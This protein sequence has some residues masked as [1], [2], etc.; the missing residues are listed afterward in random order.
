M[1]AASPQLA[2]RTPGRCLEMLFFL[3]GKPDEVR[4][5]GLAE[6]AGHRSRAH[7]VCPGGCE[8]SSLSRV[9]TAQ[10]FAPTVLVAAGQAFASPRQGCNLFLVVRTKQSFYLATPQEV[11][12]ASEWP[13]FLF[14]KATSID[15]WYKLLGSCPAMSLS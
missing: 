13:L 11:V 10:E 5:R 1:L 3:Q 2:E 4:D 12:L 9:L 6:A 14:G 7:G 8:A 15:H